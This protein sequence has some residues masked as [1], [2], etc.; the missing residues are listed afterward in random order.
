VST[1][2]G[3]SGGGFPLTTGQALTVSGGVT[4]TAGS[5]VTIATTPSLAVGVYQ[6]DYWMS[7]DG[8]TGASEQDVYLA[9][10]TAVATGMTGVTSTAAGAAAKSIGNGGAA[11]VTV[12][13]AGTMLLVGFPAAG[14]GGT[15]VALGTSL[16]AGIQGASGM[17]WIKTG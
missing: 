8:A 10:G 5:A 17:T 14:A 3:S 11:L 9:L 4:L 6:F 15:L 16:A 1:S 7:C 13:T 12:T 2:G